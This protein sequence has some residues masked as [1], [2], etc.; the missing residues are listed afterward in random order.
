MKTN[1]LNMKRFSKRKGSRNNLGI[2]IVDQLSL[3]DIYFTEFA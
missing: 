1:F 2:A 3:R